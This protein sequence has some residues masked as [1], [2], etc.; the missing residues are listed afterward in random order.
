MQAD[1][2]SLNETTLQTDQGAMVPSGQGKFKQQQTKGTWQ[3]ED[4]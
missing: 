4:C 1:R 3:A 2:T